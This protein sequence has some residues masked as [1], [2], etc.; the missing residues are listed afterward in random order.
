MITLHSAFSSCVGVTKQ[1]QGGGSK[2]RCERAMSVSVVVR[3]S[4]LL[5]RLAYNSLRSSYRAVH[6]VRHRKHPSVGDVQ[7]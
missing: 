2:Y 3:N 4:D 7:R 6:P 1:I 5:A